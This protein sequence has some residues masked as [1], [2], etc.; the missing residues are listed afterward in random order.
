MSEY[1]G[2]SDKVTL[3]PVSHLRDSSLL[4]KEKTVNS[5]IAVFEHSSVE[6]DGAYGVELLQFTIP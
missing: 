1:P 2:L 3:P 6:A 5:E 4:L